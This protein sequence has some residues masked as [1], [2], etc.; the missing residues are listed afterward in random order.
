MAFNNIYKLVVLRHIIII[1]IIIIII[2]LC[3]LYLIHCLFKVQFSNTLFRD[4]LILLPCLKKWGAV[5]SIVLGPFDKVDI[6][7]KFAQ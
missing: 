2:M 5:K 1:I 6:L 3:Q 7:S 4:R